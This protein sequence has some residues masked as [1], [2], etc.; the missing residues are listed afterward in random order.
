MFKN[1]LIKLLEPNINNRISIYEAFED[2]WIKGAEI[3]FEEKENINDSE[4]FLIN[5]ITDNVR[6]FNE[7]INT[8]K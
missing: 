2:S 4:I 8:K 6:N 7:Y 3:L 1:F 5:L